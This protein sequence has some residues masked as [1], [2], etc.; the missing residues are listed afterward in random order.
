M[1]NNYT[2][3]FTHIVVLISSLLLSASLSGTHIVGG[4]LSY[5]RNGASNYTFTLKLFRDCTP[6]TAAFPATVTIQVRGYNGLV[7]NPSKNF[8]MNPTVT[9]ALPTNLDTCAVPPN[10]LPCVQERTYT[11]TVNNL[12]EVPGGY[13]CYYQVC[14]RNL[15]TTNVNASANNIGSS[16]YCYIPGP[17]VGWFEDFTLANNTTNDNGPTSWSRALGSTQPAYASVQNNLFETGGANNGQMTWTSQTISIAPFFASGVRLQ[18]DLSEAGTLDANDS[19]LTF[20]RLNSGPLVPFTTNGAIADDFGTAV[21]STGPL[22]GS[23]I[24]IVIRV[25]FDANSPTTEIYR[26]DNVQVYANTSTVNSSPSFNTLPPLFLC[27]GEAFSIPQS[28]ID[29]D[30]DVLVYSLYTPY[31]DAA[32]TYN[33]NTATI[34]PVVWLG[35][36]SANN[37]LGGA[38]LTI[39]SSTGQLSGVPPLIG[40]FV[41]GIK[42]QEFRNNVLLSEVT[43]DFQ[44]NVTFCP[45]P[46][47]ALIAPGDTL[48]A[49]QGLT[50]NFPNGSDTAATNWSWNFGN[51]AVTNDTSN[52]EFPSY[53]YPNPGSYTVTLII[54]K[55][56]SCA[57]TSTAVVD[58]G[59]LNAAFSSNAPQC[60]GTPVSF[61]ST[62]TNSSNGPITAYSWNFGDNGT[63]SLQNPT[64]TYSAGGTYTVTLITGSSLGCTDTAT[65]VITINGA[66]SAPNP[67]SNSPICAGQTLNL[68]TSP[69]VN[70]TY[71]WTGPNGFTSTLQNPSITNATI[72]AAGTYSV[73]V[74]VNGCSSTSGV[75]TVVINPSPAAPTV[76][77]NSPVCIGNTINL[78]ASTVANATYSWTGPSGFTSS[79]QNPTRPNAVVGFSGTYSL[80]ITVNGCSSSVVTTNVVVSAQPAAATVSSNSPVCAGST[81]NLSAST[82][83]NATYSWSGPNGFTSTLQNPTI[84]NATAAAAGTYSLVITTGGC[85]SAASTVTVTILQAPAAATAS[86][87]SPICAGSTLNLSAST[88]SNATYSWSG[89]NGFT[90]TLQN[91]TIPNATTAAAGTYSLIIT[92]NGCN[93]V[94]STTVVTINPAPVAPTVSSNSPVCTGGTV[95]L[96]SSTVANATYNW[97]G[98]NG[99]TSTLQNPTIA[100]ATVANSGTYSLTVT[101]NGC[102]SA[103]TTVSVTVSSPPGTPTPSSNSPVCVG[104]TLNLSTSTLANATYNWSGPNGFTSTVQNPTIPNVTSAAAGTYS[105]T[106]NVAGCPS[107]S[108]TTT[109]VI[110]PAP[111]APTASSNS[112]ICA[113]NTINLNASTT[114]NATY[115]WSGPNG[116]TSTS[117]NPSITNATTSNSGTYSVT[118]TVNGCPSAAA[119]T[120]VIVN[121]T[122]AAPTTS[123]NSP[124]CTGSSIT[125]TSN[126]IANATYSWSG[127]NGFTSTTQNPTITNATTANSGTYTLVVTVNGC[128]SAPV[129]VNVIVS[130]PPGTPTASS[131]S[132]I[133]AGSTLN[134]ST[135]TLANAT[136]NWSG[137]NGFTSTLQNPSIPNVTAAAAGTYSLTVNVAGCPSGS[138]TTTVVILPTP[139]AP[140]VSSNSP[141][142]VG[143]TINLTSNTIANATYAWSGPNGFTSSAQNPTITNATVANSGSYSLTVTVNGCTSNA[144][145]TAVT[146]NPIPSAPTVSS[147]SPVCTG[148][149]L[150][151][152]S[153]TV[154]G[155]TYNW[156]GPNGFTST[157]QN[158][159]IPNVTIAASG[160]YTL[161]VTVNGCTSPTSTVTIVIN[162]SPSAP[163]ISSNSPICAG[164][165]INLTANSVANAT[166]NWSGPN[167]F[168]STSQNP[169]IP[170]ATSANAGSYSLTVTVNGCASIASSTT[171]IVNP[172]PA[173]PVIS[174]NSPVCVGNTITL[175]ANSVANSTYNWSG[176]N[177]FTSTVQNPTITNATSAN[178]GTY[179]L[180]ITTNGCTSVISNTVVTV[181]PIPV[182]PIVSSNSPVCAGSTLNLVSNTIAN[183]TY[184]W[185]GPNG[186]TS[187]LQNP[188]IPNT[189]IAASGTYSL[190]ATVSG[191]TSAV[192]TVT[193]VVNPTPAAPSISSNSP[194]CAGSTINLTANTVAN[195][196]YNWSGPN[197]FTS[198]LQ[199]PSITNATTSNS[200]TYSLSITVNGC[201]SSPSTIVV[202]VNP[203][204]AAP[205]ATSNSPVCS[206]NTLVLSAGTIANAQYTWSGPNGFTATTQNPAIPNVS[207]SASGTYSVSVS[208][209]GCNSPIN[210]VT[211]IINPTPAAPTATSNSPVCAGD[212]IL[213][214]AS[215]VAGGTY[216]WTGPLSFSSSQ[217]NATIPNANVLMSGSY[218]VTV[219]VNGCTSSPTI[220]NVNV[221]AQ[222]ISPVPSS[223][224]PVCEGAVLNLTSPTVVGA[225][226][227]W[228]GPNGFTSSVQNPSITNVQ[229]AAAGTYSL[230]ITVN[231]CLGTTS[232]TTVSV[233]PLPAT[234]QVLSNSPVCDGSSIILST[235][236]V[237]NATYSWSGPNGFT[238][239]LQNPVITGASF[240]NA[241]T[242]SLTITVAGCN[243]AIATVNV[244]INPTPAPPVALTN[245]PICEGS[246]LY[247]YSTSVPNATY[248]WSG[249]NGYTSLFQND[250]IFNATAAASGTYSVTSTANGCT[251]VAGTVIVVVDPL[252]IASAG[253][254]TF[255]CAS[256][257]IS[258]NGT[259]NASQ[260]IW[261][262]SGSGSFSPSSTQLSTTYLPSAS[263]T[264]FGSVSLYLSTVSSGVCPDVTDTVTFTFV[265]APL[266]SIGADISIC[267]QEDSVS[268]NAT[269]SGSSNVQWYSTGTGTFMPSNLG[270]NVYYVPSSSDTAAGQILIYSET[271]ANTYCS[272]VVDTLVLIFNDAPLVNAGPDLFVCDNTASVQLSGSVSGGSTTGVWSTSGLGVFIPSNTDLNATYIFNPADTAQGFV[273]FILTSTNNGQCNASVD[274]ILVSFTE[275]V[276][277]Q[278]GID[279]ALCIGS[280]NIPLGGIFITNSGAVQWST[281][282][283]GTFSP[284]DTVINATYTP[285]PQDIINGSVTITLTATTS[286]VPSSDSIVITLQS[287]PD[288]LASAPNF[289]CDGDSIL[290]NASLSIQ[291]N[292]SWSAL[293]NGVFIP[294]DTVTNPVY[295]P[296]SADIA[297]GFITFIVNAASTGLCSGDADTVTVQINSRPNIA[298]SQIGNCAADSIQ[299][300][301]S[302]QDSSIV[303]WQWVIGSDTSYVQ[304]PVI[305]FSSGGNQIISLTVTDSIGCSSSL[306]DS[307]FVNFAPIINFSWES[308]CE[309]TVSFE[310][311]SFVPTTGNIT[312][313]LWDFGDGNQASSSSPVNT[314]INEGWYIVNLTVTSDSGCISTV[315]DSIFADECL[316]DSV[317]NPVLPTAFTPNGDGVNDVLFV[318]GGPF[319]ELY[320]AVYNEWGN[321]IFSSNDASVGWDG[322]FK[323]T[324]QASG[325][326]VW[327]IK[328]ATI[329]GVNFNQTGVVNLIK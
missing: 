92:V 325:T 251:S 190:T 182:A 228:T 290:L 38:P 239:T 34:A 263:D 296:S 247:L 108:G 203:I 284:S 209:L 150:N 229:L 302:S 243:S 175:T 20:Y 9:V 133:C 61:T 112:P 286:C 128:P 258:L 5:V 161:S 59:F 279:T 147:N 276:L 192:S 145:S 320:F 172:T 28:A 101:V 285:G 124:V 135:A 91:P 234:P 60:A 105:L 244:V 198:S 95:N 187:T 80:T 82:V 206:G 311:S 257:T 289:I 106:V 136:Y 149:T 11:A 56:T 267:A 230:T 294:S 33:N 197:G 53:T 43:R 123:S 62:S 280:A 219:T 65:A 309:L 139:A 223:N 266:I 265:P 115:S 74:T 316:E 36:F 83:S 41:V 69:V 17:T 329:D 308:N 224:S 256:S 293:G 283:N 102:P 98:P 183:A 54:N 195:A 186:F 140:T 176:P 218:S 307:L 52:I 254:D 323:G 298:L 67:T 261:S 227:S 160:T 120:T 25:R 213:L 30:G 110:L 249:P 39:N 71:S 18:V 270:A 58:V 217:Q 48:N 317:L 241:G 271:T 84:P 129:T 250:I 86:S 130:A 236:S 4:S 134:L 125:L 173:A 242:Y 116:F 214:S 113:G 89:P 99:F 275:A 297:N 35:G 164:S 253:V 109:V 114:A 174:S 322:T 87:N 159:S 137:P 31:T 107:G 16:V 148:S 151:L 103:V 310:D 162:P 94:A 179:S 225:S 202:V 85:P 235:T 45:P 169:T 272:S 273:W 49:C 21:A 314:Y 211:V 255:I 142:C 153:A 168:T 118:I 304:N 55:G 127:P 319:A 2:A 119:T 155:A 144:T 27:Q 100:N 269:F 152:I 57:D 24:Q 132:P 1:K 306:N 328:G 29:P 248:S 47:Q 194:L 70:A 215:S 305:M 220:V 238:S 210:T 126:T 157:V 295:I 131:N 216:N 121:P 181:N 3:F 75:T 212:T 208:V 201:T 19:I 117:Q 274:S 122:P 72:A 232:T 303:S 51:S 50:V 292:V 278:T 79:L 111:T 42:V 156:S 40:Q 46:A 26:F 68:T 313:L 180:T 196:T 12:P 300:F 90:S 22:T 81:L 10:P 177:G 200:G 63:S 78:T 288:I 154:P 240:I 8:V 96:T 264:S 44:F 170:N 104:S 32:P 7:F 205:S 184:S 191:C 64:H 141:V 163:I 326:Y 291:T 189:T 312:S 158:P 97:S 6:N 199:N 73:T 277:V 315:S 171:V 226:Y 93:S 268:L 143:N 14:C 15:T 204:P 318:R 301:E 233:T 66:P 166:Y 76:S 237:V 299:F 37:P 231:G 185:S 327:I 178:S 282:G 188:S 207:I 165:N 77:S 13:H 281:S 245:A 246:N 88:V 259:S 287:N 324:L 193:V 222:P 221:L 260:I 321:L 138:G 167:G 146:V 252:P 23:T 262:S